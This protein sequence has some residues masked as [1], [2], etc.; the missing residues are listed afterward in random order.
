MAS[1]IHR[2]KAAI[3]STSATELHFRQAVEAP[4]QPFLFKARLQCSEIDSPRLWPTP[5]HHYGCAIR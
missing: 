1:Q 5:G 3:G 2:L 4:Q